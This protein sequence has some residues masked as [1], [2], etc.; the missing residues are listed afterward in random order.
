M[1]TIKFF[2]I[3]ALFLGFSVSAM[4]QNP[5]AF[6]TAGAGAKIIAPLSIENTQS[7]EFGNIVA[8]STGGT[9]TVAPGDATT[10]SYDGVA[11]PV[12]LA[13]TI[14]SAKFTVY[15]ETGANYSITIKDGA[16]GTGEADKVT[17]S[18]GVDN[19]M[20]VDLLQNKEATSNVISATPDDNVIFVGGTLHVGGGQASGAYTG[21]FN[22]TV[23]YE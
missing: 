17:L 2:A 23:A 12:G 6:A 7:L 5:T 4:S 1:K 19:I 13:N 9:V 21:T 14:Q 22:V 20:V 18:N 8:S 15:G 10:A 16:D 11:A 3:A